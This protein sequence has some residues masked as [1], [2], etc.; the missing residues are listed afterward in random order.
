ML[1]PIVAQLKCRREDEVLGMSSSQRELVMQTTAM[2]SFCSDMSNHEQTS[3]DDQPVCKVPTIMRGQ[4][5]LGRYNVTRVKNKG[6]PFRN[7]GQDK[8]NPFGVTADCKRSL[9]P[10][11]RPCGSDSHVATCNSIVVFLS[12]VNISTKRWSY[13][14]V[15][16]LPR[17]TG[18]VTRPGSLSTS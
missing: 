12:R 4:A 7:G 8:T 13:Q 17:V 11:A 6:Q 16:H 14:R 18:P 1:F 3:K 2:H 15:R 10:E 5:T 9:A